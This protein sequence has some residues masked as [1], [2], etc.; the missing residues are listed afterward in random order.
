MD[1]VWIYIFIISVLIFSVIFSL[2]VS[3]I[4]AEF[5]S[6]LEEPDRKEHGN[7]D[8]YELIAV[9]TTLVVQYCIPDTVSAIISFNCSWSATACIIMQSAYVPGIDMLLRY[10]NQ[11]FSVLLSIN[12]SGLFLRYVIPAVLSGVQDHHNWWD[13]ARQKQSPSPP[14]SNGLN[15]YL[16]LCSNTVFD[17]NLV[18]LLVF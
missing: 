7:V 5:T 16:N 10:T 8:K 17:G 2:P 9:L 1:V 15:C 4:C 3:T 12:L 13:T 14:T 18:T 11:E 6:L